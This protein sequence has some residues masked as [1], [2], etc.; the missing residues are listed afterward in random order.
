MEIQNLPEK[1]VKLPHWR[2]IYRPSIYKK[3]IEDPHAAFDLVR[4]SLVRLRGWEYPYVSEDRAEQVREQEYVASG[5]DWDG[6][7][8]YW[9]LYYSGQFI[10]LF[11]LRENYIYKEQGFI[12]ITNTLYNIAEIIEFAARLCQKGIY[13]DSLQI[14]IQIKNVKDFKLWSKEI[15]LRGYYSATSNVIEK[16][17]EV[18]V[19]DL[20]SRAASISLDNT[21]YVF[22][23]LG[24]DQPPRDHLKNE[25][26]KFLAGK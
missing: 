4:K 1:I 11:S 8:E 25:L 20:I 14:S 26:E 13:Q 16:T 6:L 21:I 19:S 7:I 9:R 2:V 10:H 3:R 12:D 15:L 17:I 18:E 23:W 22:K 5:C 24:W